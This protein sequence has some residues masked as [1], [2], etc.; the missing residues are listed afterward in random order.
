MFVNKKT[1]NILNLNQISIVR[2]MTGLSKNSHISGTLKILKIFTIH[3][4]Y[5]YMKL[6]FVKNLKNNYI[7]STIFDYL[8]VSAY[9]SKLN[10]KSFIKDFKYICN[11]IKKDEKICHR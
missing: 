7:C 4:L 2:Y 5:S 9:K 8:L 3:E 11:K 1:L 6:I 10:T